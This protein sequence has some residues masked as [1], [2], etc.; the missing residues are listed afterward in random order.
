MKTCDAIV[1][2]WIMNTVSESLLSC[3]IYATN[4]CT[5]WEDLNE[6]Y[7]KVNRMRIY[8]LHCEINMHSQGTNSISAYFTKLKSL[9]SE[10]D[11]LVPNPSCACPTSREYSD[12]M[13]QLRLLQILSGLNE[14]Y[15]QVRRQILLKGMTPTLNQAYAIS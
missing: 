11:V 15:D 14:S 1:L 2:S 8:Q 7:E 10:Y 6:R 12:H 3:I 5:V 4:A 13:C 9:W